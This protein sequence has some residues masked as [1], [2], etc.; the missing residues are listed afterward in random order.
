M[1]T[2]RRKSPKSIQATRADIDC[3]RRKVK[4][5]AA[6][7][8]MAVMFVALIDK[9]G[10]QLPQI[11]ELWTHVQAI[12]EDIQ[13]KRITVADLKDVLKQEQNIVFR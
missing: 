9:M 4:N 6:E 8:A 2:K 11:Q 10:W 1:A 7:E 5:E 13:E 12:S 3:I